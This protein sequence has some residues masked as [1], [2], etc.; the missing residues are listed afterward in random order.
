MKIA[1]VIF[2]SG[3]RHHSEL[4]RLDRGNLYPIYEWTISPL[5]AGLSTT[6]ESEP[7]QHRVKDS[8]V[9]ERAYGLIEVEGI[10]KNR[11][12]QFVTKNT[13]GKELYRMEITISNLEKVE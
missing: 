13:F 12:I 5:T 10:G 9:T 2:L 7:N 4:S 8:F 11:K 3:D 1:G 6:T